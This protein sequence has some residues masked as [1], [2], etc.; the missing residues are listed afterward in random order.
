MVWDGTERRKKMTHEKC[1][2]VIQNT[3]RLENM[4]I[5]FREYKEG[6]EKNSDE[7][8]KVITEIRDKLLSRPSWAVCVII[9]ILTS[10]TVASVTAMFN[11][12]KLVIK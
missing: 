7:L 10:I 12:L 5:S 3:Q 8:W 1:V 11:M 2:D 9:T 4:E 6:V